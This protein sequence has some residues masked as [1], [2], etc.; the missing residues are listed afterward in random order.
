VLEAFTNDC[1]IYPAMPGELYILLKMLIF[2]FNCFL[3]I[4]Q[5]QN[6]EA[7]SKVLVRWAMLTWMMMKGKLEK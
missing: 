1:I 3:F 2:F 4:E 5:A 6:V 7:C